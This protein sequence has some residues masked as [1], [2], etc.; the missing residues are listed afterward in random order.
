MRLAA[1]REDD[2]P[3]DALPIYQD[4]VER[5]IQVNKNG[6]YAEAVEWM[7]KIRAILDRLDRGD[8]FP[9]YATEVRARHKPKRNLMKLFGAAGW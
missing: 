9:A 1:A 2:H 7:H 8:E 3:G 6:A 5:T 4:H